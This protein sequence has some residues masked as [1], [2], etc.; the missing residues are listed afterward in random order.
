MKV[1]ILAGGFGTRLSEYTDTIPK[2]MV[3]IGGKPI[4]EHVCN[5]F[6]GEE[7]FT[8][9]CNAKHLSETNMRAVLKS[10]KPNANI[11]EIPN[12]KKGPVYAVSLLND[13]I[14]NDEELFISDSDHYIQWNKT[15]FNEKIR[16]QLIDA[17]VFVFPGKQKS[18]HFSYVRTN[19]ENYVVE[20]SE[21]IPISETAACGIHYYKKGSDFVKYAKKMIEKNIR[22]NNEFYV[23]P[24][25][26]EFIKSSV[27]YR[28]RQAG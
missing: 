4:I 27:L 6:P 20:A 16:T 7:K 25:Y 22:F 19:E 26:N 1:V 21:K 17:C 14:D 2:P 28:H 13:L 8:F 9:I 3:S 12:H 23:T 15:Q 11:V 5:L 24:V 18:S 10:I